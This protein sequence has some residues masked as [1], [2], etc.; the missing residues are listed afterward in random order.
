MEQFNNK[1]QRIQKYQDQA[2]LLIKENRNLAIKMSNLEYDIQKLK[3][4]N[5]FQEMQITKYKDILKKQLPGHSED[6]DNL[7]IYNWRPEQLVA[8]AETHFNKGQYAD[9]A[10]FLNYFI[11]KYKNHPLIN[12][13]LIFMAGISCYKS[14]T[15]L[16]SALNYFHII[17]QKS[18]HSPYFRGAKLW[19]G[20]I[21][22]KQ[23][24]K[25]LF[26][27]VIEEFRKKY[28]NTSEWKI[29]SA[30]YENIKNASTH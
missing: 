26:L 17:I 7:D 22:H 16:N 8:M 1:L 23:G 24:K 29:L 18:A 14:E 2:L 15:C 5:Y 6:N 19:S 20:I 13:E 11:S 4:Q 28:K 27:K 21:Y 30:Y 12:D 9:A 10:K 3:S 25:D